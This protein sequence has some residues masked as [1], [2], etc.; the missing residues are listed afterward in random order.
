MRTIEARTVQGG[1]VSRAAAT[2]IIV[3]WASRRFS[4]A[5]IAELLTVPEADVSRLITISRSLGA[6]VGP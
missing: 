5:D 1:G 6:V 4:T 2:A 3:L